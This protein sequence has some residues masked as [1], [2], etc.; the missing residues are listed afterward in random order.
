LIENLFQ[1]KVCANLFV[2]QPK[3]FEPCLWIRNF[4]R[5]WR[6]PYTYRL[7]RNPPP[8]LRGVRESSPLA[9]AGISV[10]QVMSWFSSEQRSAEPQ[11]ILLTPALSCRAPWRRPERAPCR[12]GRAEHR[13]ARA[14]LSLDW[15]S[16][17]VA[18][19]TKRNYYIPIAFRHR[20]WKDAEPFCVIREKSFKVVSMGGAHDLLPE[21]E[22]D[23]RDR[24]TDKGRSVEPG[25][26]HRRQNLATSHH[27]PNDARSS[28]PTSPHLASSASPLHFSHAAV[29]SRVVLFPCGT[30]YNYSHLLQSEGA[31]LVPTARTNPGRCR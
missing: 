20:C 29:V 3:K 4:P 30:V 6:R 26:A 5:I 14:L 15:P 25:F 19:W 10:A 11:N 21:A 13:P 17:I 7:G 24:F 23:K 31:V 12:G 2:L 1:G 16:R 8:F 9:I 28:R 22:A 18:A 27:K